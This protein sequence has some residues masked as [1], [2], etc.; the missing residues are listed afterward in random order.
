MSWFSDL[1]NPDGTPKEGV[2]MMQ[3][4]DG[5]GTDWSGQSTAPQPTPVNTG[6]GG[7]ADDYSKSNEDYQALLSKYQQG[8]DVSN[9]DSI[10]Q[11]AAKMQADGVPAQVSEDGLLIK[12]PGYDGGWVDPRQ[13]KAFVEGRG[14]IRGWA[15]QPY[16][17]KEDFNRLTSQ[18]RNPHTGA[19]ALPGQ[20]FSRDQDAPI[21]GPGAMAPGY[22]LGNFTGGGRYPL[23]SMMAPGLMAPWTTPFKSPGDFHAPNLTDDPGYQFRLD[24]ARDGLERSA[25]SQGVL[26]T[27]GFL[28]D[29]NE[30]LQGVASQEYANAWNRAL[31]ENDLKY[32]RDWNEYM[33]AYNI[34]DRNQANQFGRLSS[35]A[36]MGANAMGSVGGAGS[37]YARYGGGIMQDSGAARAAGTANYNNALQ[38]GI[39][40]AGGM[41]PESWSFGRNKSG[42]GSVAPSD[43]F[44]GAK[45][46]RATA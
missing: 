28:K 18:G 25:A 19:Q 23:A 13:D 45:P 30:E 7:Y 43:S 4:L 29:L 12:V 42:G 22:E 6:G 33:G 3:P 20:V 16:Y 27:G 5:G 37:D 46:L 32:N 35:V 40:S 9:P 1:V 11:L 10:R 41:W 17:G 34:W 8:I 24:A 36:G 31:T 39:Q 21:S 44:A 2:N 15:F 26:R 14:G 38:T